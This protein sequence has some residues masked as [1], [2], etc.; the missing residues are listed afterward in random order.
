MDSTVLSLAIDAKLIF[1]TGEPIDTTGQHDKWIYV[2]DSEN[3]NERYEL[4][5]SNG[6]VKV[7]ETPEIVW[8]QPN[9]LS[10][11]EQWIDSDSA[12]VIA[13]Q[14]GGKNFRQTHDDATM[15]MDL[16]GE[17]T[18]SSKTAVQPVWKVRYMSNTSGQ[19]FEY[20]VVAGPPVSFED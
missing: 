1:L 10:V 19:R 3:Q 17:W 8:L 6:Q 15:G 13:E 18:D 11:P 2:F 4:W 7:V 12:V 5:V 9:M 14:N 20:K 16:V